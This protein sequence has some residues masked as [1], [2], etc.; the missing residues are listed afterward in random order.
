MKL[1]CSIIGSL[2]LIASS[3]QAQETDAKSKSVLSREDVR[4]VSPALDRY[5]HDRLL[6]EVWKRPGPSP[7]DRSVVT[8]AALIARNQT[9]EMPYH[10]NLALDNGVKPRE[11]SEIITHLLSIPAGRTPCQRLRSSG[12]SAMSKQQTGY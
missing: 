6:G 5:T 1:L 3:V 8:I 4:V 9:V 7:R 11:I 2:A 12:R 10:F